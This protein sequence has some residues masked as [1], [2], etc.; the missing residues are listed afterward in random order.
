MSE[1][2]AL[3]SSL[4]FPFPLTSEFPE[5]G[6]DRDFLKPPKKFDHFEPV[7]ERDDD[8]DIDDDF[9]DFVP[10][11]GGEN[12]PSATCP[13]VEESSELEGG[14]CGALTGVD[15]FDAFGGDNRGLILLRIPDPERFAVRSGRE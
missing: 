10:G 2:V 8:G 7:E 14:C 15:N 9:D 11:G 1:A 6:L 5:E 12:I 13:L 4:A 3:I